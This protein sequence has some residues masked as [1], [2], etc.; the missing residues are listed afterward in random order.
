[1]IF[2]MFRITKFYRK[3]FMYKK[4]IF[5]FLFVISSLL[6]LLECSKSN[7]DH[8]NSSNKLKHTLT[9]PKDSIIFYNLTL[10]EP[11]N[12][13]HYIIDTVKSKVFWAIDKHNGYV[14][15]SY[16]KI[17]VLNNK[18]FNG[19]FIVNMDSIVDLDIDYQLMKGTLEKI[20]KSAD[21]F[22][23][24]KYPNS[25][26]K[27]DSTKMIDKNNYYISGYMKIFNVIKPVNFNSRISIKKDSLFAQTEKFSIDR[28]KWGLT[29]YTKDH[30]KDDN[31]FIVPIK[32]NLK[33][34]LTAHK[35]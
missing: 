1:M 31:G 3:F 28:T 6:V 35:E 13:I 14:K 9:A 20:L 29:V 8:S 19:T 23:S 27:I 2:F 22:N 26:F 10:K 21:F 4:N 12:I 18:I 33:I 11:S 7:E 24:A 17:G 30:I 34:L 16:G 15:F 5:T 32:I 25:I